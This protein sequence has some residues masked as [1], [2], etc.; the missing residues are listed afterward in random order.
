MILKCVARLKSCKEKPSVFTLVCLHTR[1][2]N[3]SVVFLS[4]S[5]LG[6]QRNTQSK[7]RVKSAA[8]GF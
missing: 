6:H 3:A 5:V 4:A 1:R 2:L 8:V 7:T